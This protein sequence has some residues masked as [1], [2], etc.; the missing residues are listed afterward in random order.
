[1]IDLIIGVALTVVIAAL[2]VALAAFVLCV[3]AVLTLGVGYILSEATKRME[4]SMEK[5]K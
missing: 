3:I 1:M 5:T 4:K 2:G